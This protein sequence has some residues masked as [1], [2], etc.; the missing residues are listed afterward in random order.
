[1]NGIEFGDACFITSVDHSP[2]NQ[3]LQ[4]KAAS[5]GKV[6]E[7][8]AT[9]YNSVLFHDGMFK[10]L[11]PGAFDI[12]LKNDAPVEMW[13]EHNESL[14]LG[15]T[16]TNLDLFSDDYGLHFRLRLDDS[17]ISWH[18]RSLVA[19]KAYTECSIG[20]DRAKTG[21]REID[22]KQVLFI[23]QARLEEVSL[24]QNGAVKTTHATVNDLDQCGS[25]ADDCKSMKFRCDNAYVELERALRRL[26][27]TRR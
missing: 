25:L 1:M 13:L 7:G 5:R 21:T 11:M 6:I 19:S 17:E 12:C 20:Y 18:A 27:R 26:D 10:V 4:R 23:Y 3:N 14:R 15:D 9:K 22:G 2:I 24:V 8:I 16:K